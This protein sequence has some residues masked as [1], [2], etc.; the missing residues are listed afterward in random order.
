MDCDEEPEMDRWIDDGG[1]EI[2]AVVQG[3]S[4][5]LGLAMVRRLLRAKGV[6]R[7][8]ATSREPEE[9]EGLQALGK[10]HGERLETVAMDVSEEAS[11]AEA[12]EQ[13]RGVVDELH[14]LINVSGVLHDASR[15]MSPEK[16]VDEVQQAHSVYAYQ[17]NALG[18]LLVAKHLLGL[19]EHDR[20]AVIANLS[21]RVGSIGDNGLGGW[22]SYRATKAAQNMMTRTLAI[23]IGQYRRRMSAICVAL[24]P[25]TVDTQLSRPFQGRV[26]EDQ[27]FSAELSAEKLL[28]VID[29]LEEGDTGSFFDY[30]GAP[31]EW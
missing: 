2:S 15:G 8:V 1:S 31:I 29:G 5:G 30:S 17:V 6:S 11:I 7:V 24:H 13:I 26:D 25:G 14:L 28:R 23:E 22:Y 3:G 18:P 19:L 20:R 10:E 27:L 21:A 16:K 9:S 12:A 4:R